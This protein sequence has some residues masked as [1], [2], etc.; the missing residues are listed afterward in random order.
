[1]N[2]LF[3]YIALFTVISI[4]FGSCRK[5]DYELPEDII[6]GDGGNGIG[7]ITLLPD[8]RYVF[9]GKVFVN[10]GQ[11]LTIKPGTIVRFKGGQGEN[12]SALIVARGGRIIANGTK[13]EPI[14]FTSEL[15]DLN[16]SIPADNSGL[17]GGLIILG[18]APVNTKDGEALIEGLSEDDPRAYYGGTDPKDDSGVLKYLSIRH[19]GTNIGKDN[20]ING[21]TLGGVGNGTTIEH[22]E[23]VSNHDDGFEFFGGTVNAKY[24][25]SAFCGD[26]AFDFDLGYRGN[27]QYLV[28]IQNP[29]K[30]E[31]LVEI[32]DRTNFPLT[33]PIIVNSTFIGGGEPLAQTTVDINSS[34]AGVFVNNIFL[35]QS[36]GIL[37]EYIKGSELDSYQQFLN[38]ALYIH[39]NVF[40]Q[41][42]N[43]SSNSIFS[44]Y[45]ESGNDISNEDANFKA[46]FTSGN[47]LVDNPGLTWG[48]S[49]FNLL[50]SKDYSLNVGSN[51]N[52]WFDETDYIGALKDENWLIGWTLL[53]Q[54]GYLN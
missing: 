29:L 46:H 50:P 38:G 14:I 43:N 47:N 8:N 28:G 32:S 42:E 4:V 20:E 41:V 33:K 37:L 19:G 24:L 31:E 36:K 21:L 16:G 35:N 25:I 3:K 6:I 49:A 48:S 30:G 53:D 45:D 40:N 34:G 12:A 11:T 17:W 9:E 23:V 51:P 1:M 39:N 22:V 27:L 44:V 52:E 54:A 15:D 7:D 18:N 13:E 5:S 2:S 10:E 26:D